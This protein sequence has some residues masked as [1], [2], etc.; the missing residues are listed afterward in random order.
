MTEYKP[1]Q[2]IAYDN[3]TSMKQRGY[4]NT[5]YID[6]LIKEHKTGHSEYYGVMIWVLMMLEQWIQTH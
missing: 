1:L 4:L 2:E 5:T 6:N 3:L